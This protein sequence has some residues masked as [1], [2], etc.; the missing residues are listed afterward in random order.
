VEGS[1][2]EGATVELYPFPA[3][4]GLAPDQMN[5]RCDHNGKGT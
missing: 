5:G 2:P 1:R 4:P 3:K